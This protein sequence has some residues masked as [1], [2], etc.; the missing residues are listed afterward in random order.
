MHDEGEIRPVS[1][2]ILERELGLDNESIYVVALE[3][4]AEFFQLLGRRRNDLCLRYPIIHLQ[5]RIG[6]GT[7]W[8]NVGN[9]VVDEVRYTQLRERDGTIRHFRGGVAV[10]RTV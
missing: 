2:R 4:R 3:L 9:R 10:R 6:S 8:L 1:L 7:A 5:A